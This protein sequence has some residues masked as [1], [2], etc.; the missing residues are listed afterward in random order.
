[1]RHL[2]LFV[3]FLLCFFTGCSTTTT[4]TTQAEPIED[5]V[6]PQV[7]YNS[8]FYDEL[9]NVEELSEDYLLQE[10]Q[11]P[12]IIFSTDIASD[13][14]E[15]QSNYYFGIGFYG[16][17]GP[18]NL[19]F[20]EEVREL[21]IDKRASVCVYTYEESTRTGFSI[22]RYDYFAHFF[23]PMNDDLIE[24]F[25]RVGI[26]AYDLSASEKV[27][28]KRNTGAVVG[29]I[30]YN[31]PAYFSDLF[32]GDIITEVNGTSITSAKQLHSLLDTFDSTQEIE[33]TYYR[34]GVPYKTS[35]TPL[36]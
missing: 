24:Y 18:A 19:S 34:D 13:I 29:I 30:Y 33:I 20:E 14:N 2:I 7:L 25:Y 8:K 6:E 35:L 16:Y 27:S 22:P 3:I 9:Y 26:Q 31:S 23:V 21:C 4:T 28:T 17:N 10:G 11:E 15:I 1:M 5:V 32:K 36:Y 12:Q